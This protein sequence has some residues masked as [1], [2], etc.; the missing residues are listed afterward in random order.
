MY[1]YM[2]LF[3]YMSMYI[4]AYVYIILYYMCICVSVYHIRRL[5]GVL[6]ISHLRGQFSQ[7]HSLS[8]GLGGIYILDQ[9]ASKIKTHNRIVK[10]LFWR[11]FFADLANLGSLNMLS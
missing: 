8:N 11:P 7:L 9:I 4:C 2:Y 10:P 1:K 6:Q 5:V 3:M